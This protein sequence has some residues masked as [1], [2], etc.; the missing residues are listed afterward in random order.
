M[1]IARKIRLQFVPPYFGAFHKSM[2]IQSMHNKPWG[3]EDGELLQSIR[4]KAGMDALV[5]ARANTISLAQ[6]QELEGG[7]GRG[8][9]SELIKRNTGIKLLKKL[10]HEFP[11]QRTLAT[12]PFTETLHIDASPSTEPA[13]KP[14]RTDAAQ[15]ASDSRA[16]LKRPTLLT[17]ALL[18]AGFLGVLIFQGQNLSSSE[19]QPQVVAQRE[20]A[21]AQSPS[22]TTPSAVI[23]AP[24]ASTTSS[25]HQDM[26]ST[27]NLDPR[28]LPVAMT[29]EPDK[30]AKV[31]CEAPHR[32]KSAS[33]TPSNPLKP[34]NYI[35]IEARTD[36]QLCVLDSQNKLS[37][38]TLKAGMNQKVHGAA[39]F[40]LNAS[41]WQGLQVFF[42]GRPVRVEQDGNPHL[43]LNS[44]PL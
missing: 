33:H 26:Q 21:Q 36:S 37:T 20:H 27:A 41:N 30:L 35:Y 14:I 38:F 24:T 32:L 44:L 39:P 16:Y 9:Y 34:G 28:A 17:G 11:E 19:Q 22:S 3:P 6:L 31:S 15:S 29:T 42:Q 4:E 12:E 5:F 8:F 2:F 18:T 10:G 1:A 25:A 7:E 40:L 23:E 13:A 43:M